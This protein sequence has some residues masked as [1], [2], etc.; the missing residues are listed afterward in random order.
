MFAFRVEWTKFCLEN[1]FV[2]YP[3]GSIVRKH[4]GRWTV[5][6]D[7]LYLHCCVE[8]AH[9]WDQT[10]P[11]VQAAWPS[12]RCDPATRGRPASPPGYQ[13]SPAGPIGHGVHPTAIFKFD[14]SH[15]VEVKTFF[16]FHLPP[17]WMIPAFSGLN[18]KVLV[19]VQDKFPSELLF[20]VLLFHTSLKVTLRA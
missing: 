11:W 12:G 18:L 13:S 19:T 6:Y 9:K 17:L 1:P 14:Y 16:D 20:L 10:C 3:N 5:A 4:L 15:W 7:T 2:Q 8:D